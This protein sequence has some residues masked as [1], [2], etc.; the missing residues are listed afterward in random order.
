MNNG[1]WQNRVEDKLDKQ[2]D[3]LT[4]IKVTLAENTEQLKIHIEGVKQT[5]ELIAQNKVEMDS[6]LSPLEKDSTFIKNAVRLFGLIVA[7]IITI[8]ELLF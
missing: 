1:D 7:A 8:K 2:A 4:A 5:R 3:D 6:R